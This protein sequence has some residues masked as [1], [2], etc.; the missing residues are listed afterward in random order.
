[1]DCQ[2]QELKS[3]SA[4][5]LKPKPNKPMRSHSKKFRDDLFEDAQDDQSWHITQP[6]APT[7]VQAAK[8]D[9]SNQ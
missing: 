2:A 5:P 9:D 8:K 3:R 4:K 1:M 6:K 7:S